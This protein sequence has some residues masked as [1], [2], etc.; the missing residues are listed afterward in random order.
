VT[1]KLVPF[2]DRLYV[3]TR[4]KDSGIKTVML[5]SM[6]ARDNFQCAILDLSS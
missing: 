1:E 3:N 5:N 4:L 6:M 2:A